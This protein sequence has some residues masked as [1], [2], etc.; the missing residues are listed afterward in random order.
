MITI[1]EILGTDS[2]S[3][4]R[5]ILNDNFNVLVDEINSIETYLDADAGTITGM[6]NIQTNSL[7]VGPAGSPLLEIT[8]SA[9]NINNNLTLNGLLT[10]NN[11][12]AINSTSNITTSSVLDLAAQSATDTYVIS[13]T[14]ATDTLIELDVANY[15]QEVTF[16][17]SQKGSGNIIIKAAPG[18]NFN[19][20]NNSGGAADEIYLLD[21]GST[22][23]LK[24]IEDS[25]GVFTYYIMSQNEAIVQ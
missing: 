11:K 19:F 25:S 1:T 23:K 16:V 13:T 21:V 10:I 18:V 15:G 5:L 8:A 24:Y 2:I 14:S 17:L 4:S 3:G 12:I 22:L 6:N 9:F 7:I 20:G